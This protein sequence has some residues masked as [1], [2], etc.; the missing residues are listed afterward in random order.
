MTAILTRDPPEPSA[1]DWSV[2]KVLDQIVFRCLEKLEAVATLAGA[3]ARD[4]QNP[5]MLFNLAESYV[6]LR[7]YVDAQRTLETVISLAPDMDPAY[8]LRARASWLAGSL[9]QARR[10]LQAAPRQDHDRVAWSWLVLELLARDY[11]ATLDRLA[12]TPDVHVYGEDVVPKAL[13]EA[14]AYRHLGQ[15]EAAQAAFEAARAFLEGWLEDRPEDWRAHRT[16]ALAHAGLGGKA[17]AIREARTATELLPVSSDAVWG[18]LPR[19][20]LAQVYAIVG[21]HDAA[22]EEVEYLLS[23]PV[24]FSVW[25]LRLDPVWDP[26]R[27]HPRFKKLVGE[28]WRAEVSP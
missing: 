27:D 24:Y 2:P 13:F 9:D 3:L 18:P 14:R 19:L 22:I 26:L 25:E 11:Q 1:L 20:T 28:N 21:E 10:D 23:I 15:Q 4:P 12:E 6:F 17:D 8:A 7:R 5:D 16:L